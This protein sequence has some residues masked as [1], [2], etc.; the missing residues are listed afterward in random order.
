MVTADTQRRRILNMLL[1]SPVCAQQWRTELPRMAARI[2]DLRAAGH[3][4]VIQKCRAEQHQHRT[5]Q[6]QYVL[7]TEKYQQLDMRE[8]V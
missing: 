8:G 7:L 4:I 6:I 2:W 1:E 5:R 3:E